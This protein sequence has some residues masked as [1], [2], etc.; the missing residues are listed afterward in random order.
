M[1]VILYY[2][3][4]AFSFPANIKLILRD[5]RQNDLCLNYLNSNFASTGR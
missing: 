2:D 5:N 1:F 4:T 3:L